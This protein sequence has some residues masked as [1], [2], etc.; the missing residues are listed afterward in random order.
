MIPNLYVQGDFD[1]V[2]GGRADGHG[3]QLYHQCGLDHHLFN[4]IH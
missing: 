2:Y 1:E 4:L 3:H